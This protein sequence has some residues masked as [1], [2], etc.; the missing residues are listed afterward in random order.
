MSSNTK[1]GSATSFNPTSPVL[2]AIRLMRRP[3][4]LTSFR[5]LLSTSP[6]ATTSPS[7]SPSTTLISFV[8]SVESIET[9][10]ASEDLR[11]NFWPNRNDEFRRSGVDGLEVPL[12]IS[13]SSCSRRSNSPFSST[14]FPS[15]PHTMSHFST[16]A[17][18]LLVK[19]R[20]VEWMEELWMSAASSW[21][22]KTPVLYHYLDVLDYISHHSLTILATWLSK[23]RCV[24]DHVARHTTI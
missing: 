20:K 12:D 19:L 8:E 7:P 22:R 18:R 15:A 2:R 14:G 5:R 21:V 17:I 16:Y 9:S 4:R 11:D 6:T 23:K 3:A 13:P 24:V 10:D 1:V